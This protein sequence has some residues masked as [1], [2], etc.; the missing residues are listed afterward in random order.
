MKRIVMFTNTFEPLVGGL[1]R[2]V[3]TARLDLERAGHLCR[4]VAPTFKGAEQSADGILRL[5]ALTGIGEKD[6][7]IP[8]PTINRMQNWMEAID[9]QIVHSHQP[10]LLGDTA[11]RVARLRKVPLVFTHHTLY[12]R[13]AHSLP[14]DP[15]RARRL[16]IE[17][18]THYANRCQVV[19]APTP[20]VRHILLEREVTSPIE[21]A[22]SGIDVSFYAS[23]SRER[24][25]RHFGLPP[26]GEVIG[27]LGRISQEKNISYLTEAILRVL[28]ARPRAKVLLIGDGDRLEWTRTR[29]AEAGLADRLIA[30]GLLTGSGLADAYA[31]MDLFVFASRTD[32]QGLVLAE[33]MAAGT[34]VVALD[35]PGARDC[36][37]HER[38]G[39]LLSAGASEEEFAAAVENVLTRG[40]DRRAMAERARA[41]AGYFDRAACVQRLL[42]VYDRALE[43]YRED[44]AESADRWEQLAQRFDAEWTPFWEKMT[45]TFRALSSRTEI[46]GVA[47]RAE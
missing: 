47:S 38:T 32:T 26:H 12:E 23:G 17:L 15:E 7:S 6:F 8:L 14:M 20:S 25:R 44:S 11:W 34:V 40:E 29:F 46:R 31:S 27:H 16:V 2:S 9:P 39:W 24:G 30:P 13:Y 3:A 19:I 10:F 33:A 21:V 4:V 28:H 18:T 42:E 5:P 35:A 37:E 36:V 43:S 22:P 45:T 41:A 1:E